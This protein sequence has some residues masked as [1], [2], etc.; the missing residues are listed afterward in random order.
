MKVA[1]KLAKGG[2]QFGTGIGLSILF[3]STMDDFV[4]GDFKRNVLMPFHMV[5]VRSQQAGGY[6]SEDAT[7]MAEHTGNFIK[8]FKPLGLNR[9]SA[10]DLMLK[11][12]E[13][14][15]P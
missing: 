6:T 4:Y 7:F 15:T 2:F 3:V 1:V 5:Q 8:K 12:A 10:K 13:Y 11:D 9:D 14:S